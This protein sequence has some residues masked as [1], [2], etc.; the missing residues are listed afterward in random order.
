MNFFYRLLFPTA[1]AGKKKSQ[2]FF[3]KLF[4]FWEK[5]SFFVNFFFFFFHEF[6]CDRFPVSFCR[7][8]T[9]LCGCRNWWWIGSCPSPGTRSTSSCMPIPARGWK[10]TRS[11]QFRRKIVFFTPDEKYFSRRFEKSYFSLSR[12]IK[13]K[14][15]TNQTSG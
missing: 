2:Y 4:F 3:V 11:E 1:V 12:R 15:N 7:R 6:F 5:K 9:F 13:V 14:Y 8:T 10:P